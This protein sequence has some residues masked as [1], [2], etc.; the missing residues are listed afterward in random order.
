MH[1][2]FGHGMPMASKYAH[3]PRLLRKNQ[4]LAPHTGQ[5][6]FGSVGIR[7]HITGGGSLGV[8]FR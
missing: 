4:T 3:P 6:A 2:C 7:R 8:P 1:G 5:F